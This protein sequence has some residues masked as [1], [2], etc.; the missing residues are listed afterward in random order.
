MPDGA[1]PALLPMAPEQ[2]ASLESDDH[3]SNLEGDVYVVVREEAVVEDAGLED[4]YDDCTSD[5]A[6]Q[7]GSAIAAMEEAEEKAALACMSD[8]ATAM[9]AD[10]TLL[11]AEVLVPAECKEHADER[12][13]APVRIPSNM[14]P[15]ASE[16]AENL[17]AHEGLEI[18]S[19][20]PPRKPSAKTAD[21][22]VSAKL[23]RLAE[24]RNLV[25]VKCS[26]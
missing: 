9:P 23:K 14:P 26:L 16:P 3:A 13:Q 10:S 18:P 17:Y 4:G 15:E 2:W 21:F 1:S 25:S 5:L 6:Q 8:S 12:L 7:L 24:L 19:Y 20:T 22:D 11:H